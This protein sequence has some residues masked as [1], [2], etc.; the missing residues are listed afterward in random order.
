MRMLRQYT[1]GDR[2]IAIE[3]LSDQAIN[4]HN[5]A[6]D[7]VNYED[8]N[9]NIAIPVFSIHGN[10]DDPSGF[11]RLSSLDLL[12][13]TGLVNYFGRWTDL[14]QVVINPILLRKGQTQ[15]AMYGLSHIHDARLARLFQSCKVV[16]ERPGPLNDESSQQQQT[17]A[18]EDEEWFHL[19]VLHQNRA[20]R[21]VKN[22]LPEESLPGF[23][24]LIIWGHEHDCR[25][26]PEFNAIRNFY[27][28]QPGS[29][30]PTSLAA[31]EAIPKHVGLL[32]IYKTKF[33]MKPLPLQ[34]VRPFVFESVDIYEM[35]DELGL[36]EGD[37]SNKVK[38]FAEKKVYEM[39]EKAKE[40]LTGHPQQPTLPLIRLRLV[41]ND[42]QHMFNAIR[43]GQTFHDK[44][45]LKTFL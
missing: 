24:N 14:N 4:F 7:T 44:V 15:L 26:E 36:D 31:G 32:E 30:V 21:G 35:V 42:E 33:Q 9:L 22:Y 13:T 28:S 39:I 3:I 1:F 19:M 11:G 2:P 23:L 20:D 37:A 43:F 45:F 29:S 16:I 41:F 8:P 17:D 6:S 40:R 12:S 34:T 18:E 25:V 5:A 10:H 38:A 27:I